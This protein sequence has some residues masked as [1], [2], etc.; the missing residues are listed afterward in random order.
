MF[1]ESKLRRHILSPTMNA[2]AGTAGSMYPGSFELEKEKKTSG[3][4]IHASEKSR[5]EF[6]GLDRELGTRAR[7]RLVCSNNPSIR[8][9]VHGRASSGTINK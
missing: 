7:R 2:A 3:N 9:A 6:K 5:R 8:N 4:K 1:L